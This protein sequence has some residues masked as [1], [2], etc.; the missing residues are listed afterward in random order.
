MKGSKNL[1]R[2]QLNLLKPFASKCSINTARLAQD[3]LG[4]L[5]SHYH[6]NNL[7]YE[8]VKIGDI[9][10]TMITPKD[11]LS[12]GVI[13]YLHGGGYVAGNIN[14]AK[15]FG[16]VLASKC[17]I[18][19]FCVEYRLAPEHTFPTAIDDSL[20]A[21]GYLLSHGYAPSRII[22][23]G[24]SA[25]G[26]LCYSLCQKLR[27]K[28]RTMPAGIIAVSPWT[29]LTSSGESYQK[30]EKAD[31]SIT[32][33]RLKYFAD[34]YAYGSILEDKKVRPLTNPNIED[35]LKVKQNPK[36][37]PLFD[38][39]E[40]MPPSLIFVGGDEIMLD[41]SVALHQKL[42]DANRESE[43]IIAPELWHAYLLYDLK[44]RDCDFDKI[45]KFIKH[46]VPPQNKLRWMA[47]DNAGKI[48]PATRSRRWSN[49]FRLS[50]T[51]KAPIDKSALQTAL[52]VTARRF[53]SIAVRLRAGLFWYYLE[54]LPHAPEV[55]DEKP[56]PLSK[57][58][59]DAI[60]KCAFRVLVY[61]NRMAVEF[62]HALTDGTGGLIFLKTLV[63][64]YLY[65]KYGVKVPHDNEI[66]DR[67]QEPLP[68]ELEDSF[69]KHQ[70]KHPISRAD[71]NAF[72]IGGKRE[73]DGYLTNTTF[74]LDAD[75]L[76]VQ[77]RKRGVTVTAFM[78]A[79]LISAT[80]RIQD[81][82][83][84]K[85]SKYKPV[86]VHVPVN[87]RRLF[88]SRT[89]R[90]FVLCATV[91]IDPK[92]GEYNFDELCEIV[93]HQMKLQINKKNM[94]SMMKTNV[95]SERNQLLRVVPLF[96]K[97]IVMKLVYNAVGEKKACFTFSN[98]GVVNTPEEFSA[99]VDRLDFVLG[100][101]SGDP[102]NVSALSYGGKT[103]LNFI[104]NINAP[105]LERE[106]YGV[107]KELDIPLTAESNT[108]GRE[109]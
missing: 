22:L 42:L 56:Y 34:C 10:C 92:L 50:A 80:A 86:K 39:Q 17:G 44:E 84:R 98:L 7:L 26:G 72:R 61:K 14:Y 51:L 77:A 100:S 63:S 28:G 57:M 104:R 32:K 52:D 108:R 43:L 107:L 35:D 12:T 15:G 18:R 40:K 33:S 16:S 88:N 105:V 76:L 82:R 29:D 58:P 37:S 83:V 81:K 89:L 21:Y 24:E 109:I 66:L 74:I 48:F 96:I 31:P 11:V 87:L 27:D 99:H 2:S 79:V 97:N 94:A 3:K 62:F 6:K 103:Y 20:D 23:C 5:M 85:A 95:N 55:L 90:N 68:E 47:L 41:D 69:I 9:K 91:G 75:T 106:V 8:N 70:G 101:Q 65:Q 19:V 36:I 71:T 93:S 4:K 73:E 49:V 45:S 30:N 46:T 64:E 54:E 102:Y 59:F 67:L 13:L 78:T 38:T 60:S 25:G 53:P 1:I